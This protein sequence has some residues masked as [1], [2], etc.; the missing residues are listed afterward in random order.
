VKGNTARDNGRVDIFDDTGTV[1]ANSYADSKHMLH[2]GTAKIHN[3]F[4]KGSVGSPF[5]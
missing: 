3:R 2:R 5:G 4:R 1:P